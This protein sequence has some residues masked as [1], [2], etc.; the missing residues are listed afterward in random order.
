MIS[1]VQA[2]NANQPNFTS[3][4]RVSFRFARLYTEGASNRIKNQIKMLENNGNKD[5]VLLDRNESGDSIYL[6]VYK[7]DKNKIMENLGSA[8]YTLENTKEHSL[9]DLYN[10]VVNEIKDEFKESKLSKILFEY[11]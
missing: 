2:Y 9:V 6:K 4:V 3:R 8:P 1:K 5:L 7:K 11:L 10:K